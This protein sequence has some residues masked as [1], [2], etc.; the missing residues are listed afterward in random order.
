MKFAKAWVYK[1]KMDLFF[2][3]LVLI[4]ILFFGIYIMLGIKSTIVNLTDGYPW[5]SLRNLTKIFIF[6]GT[7]LLFLTFIILK[8]TYIGSSSLVL[9]I[10]VFFFNAFLCFIL[11]TT[12]IFSTNELLPLKFS[13]ENDLAL[14]TKFLA[15]GSAILCSIILY[16]IKGY[17]W[18][19]KKVRTGKKEKLMKLTAILI[20]LSVFNQSFSHFGQTELFMSEPRSQSESRD[21]QINLC[22][23]HAPINFVNNSQV[24]TYF[25]GNITNGLSWESAFVIENLTFNRES[26]QIESYYG[27][28]FYNCSRYVVIKNCTFSGFSYG[29]EILYS[30]NIR[31][32]NCFLTDLYS[33]LDIK[34]SKEI[35]ILNNSISDSRYSQVSLYS[36]NSCKIIGN[37]IQNSQYTGIKLS[38][39]EGAIIERNH[40]INNKN[41]ISLGDSNSNLIK[42][43]FVMSNS[44]S[45]INVGG[46]SN[47]S[48][49]Q[50]EISINRYGIIMYNGNQ[51]NTFWYNN[52]TKNEEFNAYNL[53]H[54]NDLDQI[55]APNKWDNGS[56]G[57][58]WD[59]YLFNN[60]FGVKQ[61]EFWMVRY[62]I[63]G[64]F[65]ESDN[66]PLIH[67]DDTTRFNSTLIFIIILVSGTMSISILAYQSIKK[68]I[69]REN[70]FFVRHF[71]ENHN[72]QDKMDNSEEEKSQKITEKK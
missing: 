43:N 58:F 66:Y 45:G 59:D 39:S 72:I 13:V 9:Q 54:Y 71:Y 5:I 28:R 32:E 18:E 70:N 3:G 6:I 16:N 8:K 69:L 41:G 17:H 57:N 20:F 49:F 37:L 60:P 64:F 22:P 26:F 31:L 27:I 38:D 44:H 55:C 4:Q 30:A 36:T 65:Q 42:F 14:G 50:N 47:N 15:I 61:D 46:S 7:I 52:F 53:V 23:P 21:F 56:V 40:L 29:L 12:Y 19:K 10:I 68:N 2:G 33:S 67:I 63:P 62:K 34:N 1:Y 24:D 11:T 35:I 48:V 51:N 25:S